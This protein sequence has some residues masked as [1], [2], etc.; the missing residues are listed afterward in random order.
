MTATNDNLRIERLDRD[1]RRQ[2]YRDWMTCQFPKDELKP[3]SAIEQTIRKGLYEAWGMWNGNELVA[4]AML[5][6]RNPGSVVLLDYYGVKPELK[7]RGYGSAFLEK[8]K[9]VY[10]D[11]EMIVIESETPE[12]IDDPED[13]EIALRRLGFYAKT[14]ARIPD[15]G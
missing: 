3:L 14:A 11:W 2:V 15:S 6:Y 12:C 10:A 5:G 7:H 1:G 13:R 9:D 4:Y 8:L